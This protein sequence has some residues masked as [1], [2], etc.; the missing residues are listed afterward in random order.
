M[1]K[2]LR[3]ML[4]AD[5]AIILCNEEEMANWLNENFHGNRKVVD[6]ILKVLNASDLP[7]TVKVVF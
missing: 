5:A 7:K 1:P 4:Q 3:S 2:I 6:T